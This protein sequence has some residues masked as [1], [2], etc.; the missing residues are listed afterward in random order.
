MVGSEAHLMNYTVFGREV[1][2]ASRLE[3]ASGRARILISE[4]T[5]RELLRD[6][7]ELASL[8]IDHPPLTLKGFRDIVKAYE[9]VWLP[10]DVSREEAGQTTTAIRSR[11]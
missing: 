1:N 5:R 7:P 3:G 11:T 4:Q 10:V 9:V 2:L 6:E 8:C